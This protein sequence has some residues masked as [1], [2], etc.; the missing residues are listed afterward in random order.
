ME[1]RR[2]PGG[3]SLACPISPSVREKACSPAS[4]MR[5][6]CSPGTDACPRSF[7][8]CNFRT[9]EFRSATWQSQKRPSATV[10]SGIV[11][12]LILG[13]FADQKSRGL[14]TGQKQG[15]PL[16]E[17]LQLHFACAA[18]RLPHHGAKGVHH[19]D[20]GVRL[21]N[22]FGNLLQDR[23]Q[24]LLQHHLAQVDKA[25]GLAQLGWSK[26]VYCCW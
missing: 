23:V 5:K 26:N 24:I 3:S 12:H 4:V 6:V 21:L 10:N 8:I 1:R 25:D 15:K 11:A 16:N 17:R 9:M 19:H 18:E 7:M 2:W 20:A 22:L 13:I 14:P